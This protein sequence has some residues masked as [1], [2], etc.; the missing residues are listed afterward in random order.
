MSYQGNLQKREDPYRLHDDTISHKLC[1]NE[2]L[3]WI[4]DPLLYWKLSSALNMHAVVYGWILHSF[5]FLKKST[6]L[7]PKFCTYTKTKERYIAWEI[8]YFTSFINRFSL[9]QTDLRHYKHVSS[10][11]MLQHHEDIQPS[12]S[13]WI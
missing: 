1:E 5:N 6:C 8:I 3:R 2:N 4:M 12:S 10:W 11:Y 13:H 9:E 7:F